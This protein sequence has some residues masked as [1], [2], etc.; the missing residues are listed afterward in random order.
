LIAVEGHPLE[1]I[2]ELRRVKFV[3]KKGRIIRQ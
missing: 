3:M 1:D 2:S